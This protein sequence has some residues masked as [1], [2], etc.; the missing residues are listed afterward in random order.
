MSIIHEN[1]SDVTAK[2]SMAD[3]VKQ[4]SAARKTPRLKTSS[5]HPISPMP[6]VAPSVI[7]STLA[8]GFHINIHQKITNNFTVTPLSMS[9][10]RVV[11]TQQE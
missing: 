8:G 2:A 1:E 11:Y 4:P 6:A 5:F 7:S 9:P 3:G 10:A